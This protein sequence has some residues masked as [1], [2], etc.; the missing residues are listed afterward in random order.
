MLAAG[1]A[2]GQSEGRTELQNGFSSL[3]LGMSLE[4]VKEALTTD[5]NFL[6]EGDADVSFL[7]Y[8]ELPLIET[9]GAAFVETGVFQFHE[10]ALSVIT[11]TLDRGR[12]DYFTLY[13]TLA[14]KYG[15]PG[16]IT[17]DTAV[18]E[19]DLVRIV[20]EKPLAIKYIDRVAFDRVVELGR[21]NEALDTITRD[22]FLEQL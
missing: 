9:E 10:G 2:W 22:R 7:P 14:A 19:S 11:L 5:P 18:W 17:P 4:E 16:S 21:M 15:E 13:D 1:T 3:V 8:T 20:L 6:Y 12:L